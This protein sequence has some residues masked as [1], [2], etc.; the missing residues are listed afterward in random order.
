MDAAY[1]PT[2]RWPL[3]PSNAEAVDSWMN[4][5]SSSSL[6][7]RKV[8]FIS[9]EIFLARGA[10]IE[11]SPIDLRVQFRRLPFVQRRDPGKAAVLD[12]PLHHKPKR[13]HGERRRR[14]VPDAFSACTA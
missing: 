3:R 14:V 9:N 10:A 11:S 6:G 2:A 8:M 13:V 7:S 4:R 12:Q 5:F 1:Q